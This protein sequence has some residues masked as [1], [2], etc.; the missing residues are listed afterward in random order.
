MGVAILISDKWTLIKDHYRRQRRSHYITI[1]V[2][3]Q[4]E[5]ICTQGRSSS[6]QEANANNY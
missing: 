3:I 6:I 4:E 2:S 1:K 5:A